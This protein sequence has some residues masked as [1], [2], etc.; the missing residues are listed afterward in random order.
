[1]SPGWGQRSTAITKS[2]Q[3]LR[4]TVTFEKIQCTGI[5]QFERVALQQ[6]EPHPTA[7]EAT[8]NAMHRR[9]TVRLLQPLPREA[10][11]GAFRATTLGATWRLP[12]SRQGG[13]RLGSYTRAQMQWQT[14]STGDLQL[15]W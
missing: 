11:V 12:K 7:R 8:V 10:A 6:Y 2:G 13:V 4:G 14:Q 9:A 1:M 3:H 15:N 5:P